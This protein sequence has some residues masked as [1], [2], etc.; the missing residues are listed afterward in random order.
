M[1]RAYDVLASTNRS[2][3]SVAEEFGYQ[4]EASFRQAFKK[5]VGIGPGAVRRENKT[6]I[7]K[8]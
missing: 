1:M 7:N 2:V 8:R 6:A 3:A 5:H 4:A